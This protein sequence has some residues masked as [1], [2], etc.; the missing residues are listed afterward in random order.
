MKEEEEIIETQ[1][2][3][4]NVRHVT[5]G[6][7]VVLGSLLLT[8]KML[9][10]NPNATDLLVRENEPD[11]YQIIAPFELIVNVAIFNDFSRFNSTIGIATKEEN[12]NDLYLPSQGRAGGSRRRQVAL[13]RHCTVDLH[14]VCGRLR[15]SEGQKRDTFCF[16]SHPELWFTLTPMASGSHCSEVLAS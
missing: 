8:P 2:I 12:S 1:F 9:M 5:D 15:V 10:F 11:T 3:K 6:S 7:G 13:G 16:T 14:N 4:V